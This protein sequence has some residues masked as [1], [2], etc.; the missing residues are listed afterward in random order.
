MTFSLSSEY[1]TV[2]PPSQKFDIDIDLWQQLDAEMIAVR[3]VFMDDS[4]NYQLKEGID[5][6]TGDTTITVMKNEKRAYGTYSWTEDIMTGDFV[7]KDVDQSETWFSI[8]GSEASVWF[9]YPL[10]N[11]TRLIHHDPR[12]SMD[13]SIPSLEEEDEF[14]GNSP[15]VMLLGTMAGILLVGGSFFLRNYKKR[16]D[17]HRYEGGDV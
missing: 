9:S 17:R 4:G 13:P 1:M 6:E 7:L 11:S 8:D 15:I 14:L 5:E 16:I 10:G 12:M 2:E 3:H